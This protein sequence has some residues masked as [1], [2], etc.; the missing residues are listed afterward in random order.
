MTEETK[1]F[2]LRFPVSLINAIEARVGPRGRNSF[3]QSAAWDALA[4]PAKDRV[5]RRD[6]VAEERRDL[7]AIEHGDNP[8]VSDHVEVAVSYRFT[9]DEAELYEL[10]QRGQITAR[11]AERHLGWQGLRFS[12]AERSLMRMGLVG[13]ESGML[14]HLK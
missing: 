6:E 11:M 2:S 10:V 12:N 4:Q 14:V 1:V 7:P 3:L 9:D 8:A 13:Y 5:K